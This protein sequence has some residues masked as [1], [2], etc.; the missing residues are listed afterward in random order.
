MSQNAIGVI[1]IEGCMGGGCNLRGCGPWSPWEPQN[2]LATIGP[3][4]RRE[5][6]G[7]GEGERR[8]QGG[9]KGT[10]VGGSRPWG[11]R[12]GLDYR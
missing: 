7:S 2:D 1:K 10:L 5:Q 12:N 9:S 11:R 6:G 8:E 3:G 4:A